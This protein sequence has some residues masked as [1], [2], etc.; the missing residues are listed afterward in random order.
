VEEVF[1]VLRVEKM[2]CG[3]SAFLLG[4]LSFLVC[5]VVVNCGEVVVDCVVNVVGRLPLFCRLKVGQLFQLYFWVGTLVWGS[6]SGGTAF[7]LG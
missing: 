7:A 3:G 2:F 4:I 5:F 1:R 6:V